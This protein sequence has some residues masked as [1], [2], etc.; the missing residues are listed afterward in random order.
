MATG[1]FTT[2]TGQTYSPPE[3]PNGPLITRSDS[4]YAD[5]QSQRSGLVLHTLVTTYTHQCFGVANKG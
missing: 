2:P 5:E 4:S 3:T 1:R